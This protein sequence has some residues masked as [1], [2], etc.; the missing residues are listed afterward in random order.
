MTNPNIQK[1]MGEHLLV[2]FRGDS[3][4][5]PYVPYWGIPYI[6]PERINI[7]LDS[8]AIELKE[9]VRQSIRE[10][11]L[12]LQ[13][14]PQEIAWVLSYNIQEVYR[15]VYSEDNTFIRKTTSSEFI[16]NDFTHFYYDI[17]TINVHWCLM[18]KKENIRTV[19]LIHL[20]GKHVQS[21]T[22]IHLT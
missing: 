2:R 17:D 5:V 22:I 7:D 6:N 19:A 1:N 16:S 14:Y 8:V 3:T 4:N 20:T 11:L 10:N 18:V 21:I 15:K 12:F 13:N 9:I